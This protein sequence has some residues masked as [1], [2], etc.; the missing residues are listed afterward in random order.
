MTQEQAS[1]LLGLSKN[2]INRWVNGT[3]PRTL[4]FIRTLMGFL[5]VEQDTLGAM[6]LE[7]QVRRQLGTLP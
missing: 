5:Q 2:Q 7:S 1:V 4:D 3:E 6:I